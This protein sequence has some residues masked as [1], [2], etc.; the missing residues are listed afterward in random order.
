M[1][2][3]RLSVSSLTRLAFGSGS[4]SLAAR[5]AAAFQ[6]SGADLGAGVGFQLWVPGPC[7]VDDAD[8]AAPASSAAAVGTVVATRA[9]ATIREVQR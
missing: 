9:T 4:A 2:A 7:R 5:P 1:F 3:V 8:A 6:D